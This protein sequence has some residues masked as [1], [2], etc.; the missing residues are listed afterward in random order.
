MSGGATLVFDVHLKSSIDGFK[1]AMVD[2]P[3]NED[4]NIDDAGLMK[5]LLN[6]LKGA[7]K[8]HKRGSFIQNGE[9]YKA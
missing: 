8:K 5:G 7:L 2:V 3:L 4:G 6:F 1:D 9:K